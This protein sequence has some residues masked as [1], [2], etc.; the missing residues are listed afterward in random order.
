MYTTATQE[1][2]PWWNI[3]VKELMW[4]V[5]LNVTMFSFCLKNKWTYKNGNKKHVCA[6]TELVNGFYRI[7]T[8]VSV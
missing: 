5:V 2:S 8:D 3:S 1:T 7:F 4:S 6:K